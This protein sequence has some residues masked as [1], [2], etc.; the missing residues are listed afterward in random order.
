[1]PNLL[2]PRAAAFLCSREAIG[3]S[4]YLCTANVWTWAG[5]IA[6]SGGN[7][8][9]QYKDNP[10]PLDKCLRATVDLIRARYLP[11]VVKAFGGRDL[12]EHQLAAALS[13]EWRNG[14]ISRAQWVRDFLSGKLDAARANIMQWTNF[15]Q[16]IARAQAERDL[17]FDAR[18]PADLRASVFTAKWPT[19]KFAGGKATDVLPLLT[20]IM[21]QKE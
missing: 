1:M 7:Q 13:F 16:Q 2:T 10:Q 5:G 14:S 21:G 6:E 12:A 15:G 8:V 18:W 4:A 17:F 3:L 9:R 20:Q 11:D 19:Y